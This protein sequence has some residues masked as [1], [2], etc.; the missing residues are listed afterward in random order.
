M[1]SLREAP[2]SAAQHLCVVYQMGKVGSTSLVAALNRVDGVDAVQAHFLGPKSL[3]EILDT[4]M[5]PREGLYFHQHRLGQFTANLDITRR[6]E[7]IRTGVDRQTVLDVV[8]LVREPVDWYR[9]CLLQ[10]IEGYRSG[11]AILAE[12]RCLPRADPDGLIRLALPWALER[13]AEALERAGGLDPF[14]GAHRPLEECFSD[15]PAPVSGQLRQLLAIFLRPFTWLDG[16]LFAYLK[17]ARSHFAE[18]AAGVLT[19]KTGWGAV[20]LLRYEELNLQVSSLGAA[21][22]VGALDL[23]REN[24]SSTKPFSDA[25]AASFA[26]SGAERL[27]V[28]SRASRFAAEH[29]YAG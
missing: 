2:V 4:L 11:L 19:A 27:R 12:H 1:Q 21:L 29:G 17:L 15:L 10:D 23:G 13:I 7:A 16:H 26:T 18:L 25:V 14:L 28:L 5:D 22:G 6:V 9:S 3:H 20:H 8:S 24:V